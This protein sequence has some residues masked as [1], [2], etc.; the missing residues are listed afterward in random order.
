MSI[1]VYYQLQCDSPLLQAKCMRL[2]AYAR[3][4]SLVAARKGARRLG[5]SIS[6]GKDICPLCSGNR[7]VDAPL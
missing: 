7:A 1:H 3:F 2:G 6:D 4:K 5:W